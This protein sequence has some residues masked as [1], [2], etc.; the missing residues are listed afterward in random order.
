MGAKRAVP[1]VHRHPRTG[2]LN[3]RRRIPAN[4]R[5][6]I[7]GKPTEFV[8][9]LAAH[10]ITA[11][12][13]SE[14]QKAAEHEFEV[15]LVKARKA[16]A[17]GV[18]SVYDALT[19]TLVAFLADYYCSAELTRDEQARWGRP[20]LKVQY[21]SRGDR[22]QDYID[23]REMLAGYQSQ[24]L[25]NLWGEW[26]V[27]Y[28][29]AMGYTIDPADPE[30][31]RLLEA[32]AAAACNLWIA[33]ET[34]IDASQGSGEGAATPPLPAVPEVANR[35]L[36]GAGDPL[37][38][39]EAI[40]VALMSSARQDIGPSTRQCSNTALKLFRDA[41]GTPTPAKITR[42][43]VSGWIDLMAERPAKL[44]R[45]QRGMPL[46]D[47]VVA[48]ADLKD[49][50]RLSAKTY[51]G[52]A[53]ALAALWN[54]ARKSGQISEDRSNPFADQ[55][56]KSSAPTRD[57]PKGFNLIELKAIF[58]LP[59]FTLDE[60]PR[61]GKGHASYWIPLLLL[62]TGAR[63]EEVAQLM[64]DDFKRDADGFWLITYTDKGIHPHKGPRSLKTTR[65]QSGRRT[66]PMAPT[67]IALG[68]PQYLEHLRAAG[69]TALFPLLRTRGARR[70]LF[71]AWSEWWAKLI[72]ETGILP[73]GEGQRQPEVDLFDHLLR[74]ER[75]HEPEMG[76]S[77]IV[78][79]SIDPAEMFRDLIEGTAQRLVIGKI[80]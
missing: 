22:E 18:A 10:S 23:S 2:H 5:P 46:R 52:H 79:Q 26:T 53:S 32:I 64:I 74:I 45:A 17:A 76:Y 21:A 11:P 34:R 41:H 50:P 40:A 42:S 39:F 4:L 78:H 44:P 1:Y 31:G 54:K 63:P 65:H 77:G 3:Y 67:L 60:R 47:V 6:Y 61:G 51:N 38:S 62:W 72:Y 59:I 70:L 8:R 43:M 20:A 28:A 9:T 29:N 27:T 55:R 75:F 24:A 56:V 19:P 14:R 58:A 49:V 33:L 35:V 71:S 25:N 7:P 30:F 15:M 12:G 69:E 73:K 13:A 16:S 48:Y 57:E 37:E 68:L 36:G 66:I 80:D